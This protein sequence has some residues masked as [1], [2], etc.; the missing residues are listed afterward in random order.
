MRPGFVHRVA[1]LESASPGQGW[2]NHDG[3]AALLTEARRLPPREPWDLPGVGAETPGFGG[4][5]AEARQWAQ[6]AGS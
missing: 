5:L 3:L 1:L 4:L 6:E 2:R